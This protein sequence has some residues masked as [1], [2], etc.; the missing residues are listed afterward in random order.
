[1]LVILLGWK[2]GIILRVLTLWSPRLDERCYTRTSLKGWELTKTVCRH[3]L[4]KKLAQGELRS[5]NNSKWKGCRATSTSLSKNPYKQMVLRNSVFRE[6]T[7]AMKKKRRV[8]Q[9]SKSMT[10]C[11]RSEETQGCH[12]KKCPGVTITVSR[13]SFGKRLGWEQNMERSWCPTPPTSFVHR[14]FI[15]HPRTTLTR[16]ISSTTLCSEP[17]LAVSNFTTKWV[18]TPQNCSTYT[19]K[20]P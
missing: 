8:Q 14:S 2:N 19:H 5:G 12:S 20:E 1:M 3:L 13:G 17:L 10:V 4:T 11:H 16:S 6:A 15:V 7:I 9:Y 18:D